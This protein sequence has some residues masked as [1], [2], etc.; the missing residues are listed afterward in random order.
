MEFAP[1]G[2]MEAEV[3]KMTL[4]LFN[5]TPECVGLTTS[6]GTESIIM[7]MLAYREWG[8]KEK[9]ITKPNIVLP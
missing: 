7:A 3:I 5:G 8:R 9:G 6:G 4:D 2:Q 1:T